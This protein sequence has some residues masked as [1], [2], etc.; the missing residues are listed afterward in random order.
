[1]LTEIRHRLTRYDQIK[2][3]FPYVKT[4]RKLTVLSSECYEI[5]FIAVSA[6]QEKT[7][8]NDREL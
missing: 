5:L 2:D 7:N 4:R 8:R 1:M 3:C 6:M